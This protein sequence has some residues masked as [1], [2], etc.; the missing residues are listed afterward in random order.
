MNIYPI[1]QRFQSCSKIQNQYV[2]YIYR[3]IQQNGRHLIEAVSGN[4]ADDCEVDSNWFEN[5]RIKLL[6]TRSI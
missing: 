1:G 6:T 3:G 5:R 4:S 2:Q